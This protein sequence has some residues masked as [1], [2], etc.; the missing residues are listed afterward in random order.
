M[1]YKRMKQLEEKLVCEI[2]QLMALGQEQDAR[3]DNSAIDIPDAIKRR[4]DRLVK[5]NTAKK[6]IEQR[7]K[8]AYQEEQSEFDKKQEARKH[9]ERE[10]GKKPPSKAP[11]EP[12]EV[13]KDKDQYNFTDP[14][15]RIMKTSKGFD[16]CYNA[17]IAVNDDMLM[18][19]NYANAHHNDKQE[20]LPTLASVPDELRPQITS[21]V[22]ELNNFYT[23]QKISKKRFI[24]RGNI[25]WN[26]FLE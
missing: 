15:S 24:E 9:Y 7:R 20:F 22:A 14:A 10:T 25:Q 12:S 8:E 16:Q 6:F 23:Q 2:E 18:V 4:K 19:S 17:Q 13:P 5:I 26:L 1:S 3:D 21:S 11:K